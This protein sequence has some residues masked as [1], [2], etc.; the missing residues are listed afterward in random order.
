MGAHYRFNQEFL[1]QKQLDFEEREAL[2]IRKN[3]Q[4][5]SRKCSI[6][7]CPFCYSIVFEQKYCP[8]CGRRL[9]G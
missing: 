7:Q 8:M 4:R 2:I 6:I 5:K 3:N 9:E 1:M